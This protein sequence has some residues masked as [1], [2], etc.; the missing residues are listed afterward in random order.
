MNSGCIVK[1]TRITVE[2]ILHLTAKPNFIRVAKFFS[3]YL[4]LSYIST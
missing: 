3:Q 2:Y 4:R 1:N